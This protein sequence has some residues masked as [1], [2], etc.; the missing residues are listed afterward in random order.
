MVRLPA[1]QQR[2]AWLAEHLDELAGSGIIYT[3]TVAAA[4]ETASFLRE[5]GHHVAA[6]TGQD[7][8]AERKAAED[9]LLANELKALV[10]TSA[11]GMGFDK[12]DLGFIVHLGAP[13][14]P[15]AYYQQIGRAGRA[16]DR[17]D[18]ILLPGREDADIWAYFGS[19]AFP[20][21]ATVRATL[22]ALA[23]AGRPLSTAAL[24]TRIDLSRGRMEMMLKVLDVDGAVRR[25]SGGWAATGQ[26]WVYDAD[27][28]AR[29]AA[30]RAREQQ[31]MLGYI[32][33]DGCRM[34][35]LRRELDDPEA[36]PCGRC[37]NCTG[38]HWPAAVSKAGTAAARDRLLR[39][40][41]E[42][43]PRRMWPTGMAELGIEVSG[44]IGPDLAAEPGRALGRLTD[45]GWGPRLRAMLADE[46]GDGPVP[47]DFIA[48]VVK[49]L[50]AWD[51]DQ[52]PAGVVTLPSRTRPQL[53][54]SLG[55]RIAEIGRIPYLGGLTYSGAVAAAA[56]PP[57]QQ[58][59]ATGRALARAHCPRLSG[60]RSGRARRPGAARR[61][62]GRDRLDH[63]R[64]RPAAPRGRRRSGAAAGPRGG[65]LTIWLSPCPRRPVGP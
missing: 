4:H 53:V 49:V 6:Y 27:R 13:Q 40:G 36:A 10:A 37:D 51:W 61:R 44:K 15:I 19:L 48:A 26:D 16:V 24:E 21:E 50:A 34:E 64:R 35:Y 57:V 58:R 52:R 12:P 23:D 17:A 9:S 33:T 32:A 55:H 46:S 65:Q 38:R 45:L 60:R 5:R 54:E 29:V 11:L 42:I 7:D 18:V 25:V 39:P 43:T 20:P 31:A 62:P 30:E 22:A 8:H 3:L 47:D 59:P 63:D 1:A 2:L 28:Y 14:S 56:G 41:V